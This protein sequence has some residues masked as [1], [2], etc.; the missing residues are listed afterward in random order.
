MKRESSMALHE[1]QSNYT[2]CVNMIARIFG[3]NYTNYFSEKGIRTF[4]NQRIRVIRVSKFVSSYRKLI[5][6]DQIPNL[7]P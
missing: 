2:K 3:T 6:K 7:F 5:F 4:S 1:F